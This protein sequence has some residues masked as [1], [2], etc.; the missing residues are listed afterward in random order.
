MLHG[1]PGECRAQSAARPVASPCSCEA[2]TTSGRRYGPAIARAHP[3]A[4]EAT[5]PAP[6]APLGVG[7]ER[8]HA[9]PGFL[10]LNLGKL[11][12]LP[13]PIAPPLAELVAHECHNVI[14]RD[15]GLREA[16]ACH[17]DRL[18]PWDRER[19]VKRGAR[20]PG[21]QNGFAVAPRPTLSA[22]VVRPGAN[23]PA[24]N[25][26]CQGRTASR[27]PARRPCVTVRLDR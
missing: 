14:E 6:C 26:R 4:T 11:A 1:S 19:P 13:E 10:V 3:P 12:G 17:N 9:R 5:V 22:A 2:P 7:A 25:F 24:I 27:S 21:H 20:D 15:A 23:A 18:A 16:R 8:P